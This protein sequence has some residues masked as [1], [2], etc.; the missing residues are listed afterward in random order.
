M[1]GEA[2][3]ITVLTGSTRPHRDA[4]PT[5]GGVGPRYLS[6]RKPSGP[7]SHPLTVLSARPL[8]DPDSR[9]LTVLS[10]RPPTILS[11][12]PPT[13]LSARPPTILSPRP[14]T[15]L[16]ARPPTGLDTR[17]AAGLS[18]R[19]VAR[20]S[21]EAEAGWDRLALLDQVAEGGGFAS[22]QGAQG[23]RTLLEADDLH[24]RTSTVGNAV[25]LHP[26]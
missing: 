3:L 6:A 16:S 7:D 4:A 19:Q 1:T 12:R 26:P 8:S 5:K 23:G 21:G 17:R 9:P 15:I 10:G 13:I 2:R 20:V 24:G 14:P 11:A 22:H 18:A 25:A